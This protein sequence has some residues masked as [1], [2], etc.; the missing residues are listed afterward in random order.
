MILGRA[1]LLIF[2]QFLLFFYCNA[3][4]KENNQVN[5]HQISST[6]VI[7]S[8]EKFSENLNEMK[9]KIKRKIYELRRS[10]GEDFPPPQKSQE[11]RDAKRVAIS[12]PPS[13]LNSEIEAPSQGSISDQKTQHNPQQPDQKPSSSTP[14]GGFIPVPGKAAV[15]TPMNNFGHIPPIG[16]RAKTEPYS[17]NNKGGVI[18]NKN[19]TDD[20]AVPDDIIPNEPLK[21]TQKSIAMNNDAEKMTNATQQEQTSNE[22]NAPKKSIIIDSSTPNTLKKTEEKVNN[23]NTDQQGLLE[24]QGMQVEVVE[25]PESSTKAHK[26]P[27]AVSK[28]FD[29]WKRL[30]PTIT[31]P[32]N[33]EKHLIPIEI[34]N[35][36]S[37]G[38]QN[39]HIAPPVTID[40]YAT[41]AALYTEND[42][43]HKLRT[44]VQKIAEIKNINFLSALYSIQLGER[45]ENLIDYAIRNHKV[46][47][48]RFLLLNG[49]EPENMRVIGAANLN[50]E[51]LDLISKGKQFKPTEFSSQNKKSETRVW[52]A[53]KRK[54]K[55]FLYQDIH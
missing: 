43:P 10:S 16:N 24:I 19:E 39:G 18:D 41:S 36:S 28:K 8:E 54:G 29:Q 48:V 34:L 45:D 35:A 33:Q 13:A 14:S 51:I 22:L 32:K 53:K 11:H 9:E 47:I 17:K 50:E 1:P 20:L 15:N 42:D 31:T 55:S 7:S 3:I 46:K 25:S 5:I 4:A 6:L 26:N 44:A 21:T 40:I 52:A 37:S 49:M 38:M 23:N 27:D 2:S 12:P 30:E